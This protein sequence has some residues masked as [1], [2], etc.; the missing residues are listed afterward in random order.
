[1]HMIL[2][3]YFNWTYKQNHIFS[4][5]Y[6]Q[7]RI[8]L[9]LHELHCVSHHRLVIMLAAYQSVTV[10]G[11]QRKMFPKLITL[12]AYIF[13][14]IKIS[15]HIITL[16]AFAMCNRDESEENKGKWLLHEHCSN[17]IVY[18]QEGAMLF[19]LRSFE[20]CWNRKILMICNCSIDTIPIM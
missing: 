8:T 16:K 12:S 10:K 5:M 6:I 17:N 9:V 2:W 15:F 19:L 4:V 14:D 3:D 11:K 20:Q 7:Y 13:H 1:M 18:M